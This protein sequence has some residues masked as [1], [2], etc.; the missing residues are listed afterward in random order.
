MTCLSSSSFFLSKYLTEKIES[1]NYSGAQ[2]AHALNNNNIAALIVHE[3][4]A[5]RGSKNW[6][7]LNQELAKNEGASALKLGE[8]YLHLA[9]SEATHTISNT[10]LNALGNLSIN[11]SGNTLSDTL[12]PPINN[13]SIKMAILWFE[14]GIRLH[15]KK[16]LYALANLYFHQGNIVKAEEL[17]THKLDYIPKNSD[18]IT[19]L[20]LRIKIAIHQGDVEFVDKNVAKLRDFSLLF[21]NLNVDINDLLSDIYK[22][23]VLGVR[24][25]SKRQEVSPNEQQL[26]N[27]TA[28]YS[29]ALNATSCFT[30]LQLFATNLKHLHHLERL[31]KS[32][33]VQKMLGSYVC[34][35]PP[36][37]IST[38]LLK[39]N[40][41]KDKAVTCNE[42]GWQAV[43][44]T[45]NTRHVG[46][47][48]NK[49][50]ANVHLGML[51]F[52][53]G[54]SLNVFS[55]EVSHLLGFVD[56]YPLVNGHEKCQKEQ[57]KPF[58]HN[59]VVLKE[60]YQGE[61]KALRL[62]ILANIPW[63][64]KIKDNT[65]ILQ[66][67]ESHLSQHWRIG[68][69]ESYSNEVGLHNAESCNN[70]SV[71]QRDSNNYSLSTNKPNSD[72]QSKFSAFKPMKIQT[73]LRYFDK[74][75]PLE[76]ISFLK[77]NPSRF[78][79]PSFHYNI[80]FALFQEGQIKKAKYWLEQA[81]L[82]ETSPAKK[83]LILRGG[84]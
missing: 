77:N 32:F 61:Q 8:W 42:S 5:E 71:E 51:Y 70:Y 15:S 39:C 31:I 60:F 59:L 21:P 76:Y 4:M 81:A 49:G 55:H 65:P 66:K 45:I 40:I 54:D 82:W 78:V 53:S 73:Q 63:A 74:E 47:L 3:N 30:S 33:K 17:L 43:A 10:S 80:A 56:E 28:N 48:L 29:Q 1:K 11:V 83:A 52:D 26:N 12:T 13:K 34:F 24:K 38:T 23:N 79:M 20:L 75:F 50:G 37:Y 46:L 22:F 72:L 69:P 36:R 18:E 25:G 7:K 68:T 58:A 16:A 9:K 35:T 44:E 57:T 84:F 64:D 27:Y 67:S 62:K 41:V 19:L 2:L 14:Q 6:I